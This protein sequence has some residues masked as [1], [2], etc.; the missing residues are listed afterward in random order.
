MTQNNRFSG[1]IGDDY[2]LFKLAVPHFDE[3]Q[4]EIARIVRSHYELQPSSSHSRI[5]EIGCGSGETT[6]RILEAGQNI[7]VLALDND[8]AM[9]EQAKLNL[10]SFGNRVQLVCGDALTELQKLKKSAD[11]QAVVSGFT[12]HNLEHAY[13]KDLIHELVQHLAHDGMYVNADKYA[14]DNS[15]AHE[16]DLSEQ[17]AAFK[18]FDEVGRPDLRK[19]W[20]NHYYE[21]EN[22][23]W[24]E[25]DER[26]LLRTTGLSEIKI[27]YR[28]H[29]EAIITASR[30]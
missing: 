26:S 9:L 24:T 14:P 18:I 29:M 8:L 1:T 11:F 25:S 15:E 13:R 28:N 21:D 22:T 2:N 27:A 3:L 7:N 12:L 23:R 10:A 16:K 17:I 19:A 30:Q 20:T 5:I 6:R 4:E